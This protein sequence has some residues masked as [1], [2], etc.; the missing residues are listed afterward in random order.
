[1]TVEATADG[2]GLG[3]HAVSALLARVADKTG[4]TRAPSRHLAPPQKRAGSH[5]RGRV[6]H[7]LAVVLADSGD[8]LTDLGAV[9]DQAALFRRRRVGHDAFR[10][11]D[12][13]ASDPEA[14]QRLRTGRARACKLGGAARAR[15]DR[16]G[17]DAV[18]FT[19]RQGGRRADLE[20]RLRLS[21]RVTYCDQTGETLVGELRRSGPLGKR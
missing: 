3:S 10:L 13:I 8:C 19:L 16:S 2:D 21:P 5:D 14:I 9:R 20:T 11:I 12:Q 1:M 6:I 15:D 7:D 17:R 4:L 18:D